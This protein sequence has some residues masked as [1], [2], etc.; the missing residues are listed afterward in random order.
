MKCVC[1]EKNQRLHITKDWLGSKDLS[2]LCFRNTKFTGVQ[3]FWKPFAYSQVLRDREAVT[4]LDVISD[5]SMHSLVSDP[6]QSSP[7]NFDPLTRRSSLISSPIMQTILNRVDNRTERDVDILRPF[8]IQDYK[9]SWLERK[10]YLVRKTCVN[11][12]AK[13]WSGQKGWSAQR[14][15]GSKVKISNIFRPCKWLKRS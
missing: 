9:R 6:R 15:V 5:F 10:I 2:S 8:M 7:I 3:M 11:I 14:C 1:V 12:L 4:L 13:S